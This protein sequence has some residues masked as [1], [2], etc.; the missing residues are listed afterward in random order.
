M[1]KSERLNDM[2]LFLNDKNVFQLSD[3]MTKYDISRSTAIR[4]VKSLE[5]IGMPIY[6]ER[7]RNGHYQ[8][9]RNRLLSPI[10]FN[11]DEV[12]A[13]YFSMLTLKAYETTPFHLSV[14]K[15]KTKFERCLSAEKI[16]MLRKTEEVFSL[17]YIKHNNQCE[18]LDVILQFTMEEKVCQINYDKKGIEKTYVVQFYNISSAYGQWYVTSYNF[19]TKRMQVFRCDR[20][21]ELE[22]NHAFEA[23]KL[24]DLKSETDYLY[25]KKDA[26]NF[27]VEIAS[28]GVDLFFKENY[29]SMKL[30]QEQG[31]NVIRGF[32][33]RGEE[34]FIINY[35]L[36]FGDKIN[37][38]QP[39]SLK[40]MLLNELKSLQNHLQ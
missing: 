14:E 32:Y 18:F 23:K 37:M 24:T 27:E 1:K 39:D 6:S 38:V 19:E 40:E 10:V 28:N 7:G 25:K 2:M 26:I 35:L 11:I 5:E 3:I 22:E 8:V 17:G 30:N 13:L 4:D 31:R 21:L 34:P 9:L 16:E 12:F 33:N 29:P 15:L 20:I 36:G